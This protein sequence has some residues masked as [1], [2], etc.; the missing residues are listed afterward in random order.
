M[1]SDEEHQ[2]EANITNKVGEKLLQ[3]SAGQLQALG[4][5]GKR[6]VLECT[7]GQHCL[8]G[9]SNFNGKLLISVVNQI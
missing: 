5:D 3:L 4:G 8:Y 7:L 6:R 9:L 1:E 2:L